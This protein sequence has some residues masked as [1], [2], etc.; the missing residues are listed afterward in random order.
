MTV[1]VIRLASS[2]DV[3]GDVSAGEGALLIKNPMVI[4]SRHDPETQQMKVGMMPFAP[5][6]AG[7]SVQI[8]PHAV[9]ADYEPQ[10]DLLNEY[11]RMFGSGIVIAN[12]MP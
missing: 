7:E 2:E 5:F 10:R 4:M 11:N 3:I 12:Q 8:Y 9:M 6:S 1:M